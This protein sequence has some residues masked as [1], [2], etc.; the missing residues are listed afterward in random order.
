MRNKCKF[1]ICLLLA[2]TTVSVAYS[3]HVR[4]N[5]K[6]DIECLSSEL[7]GS[8]T[9]QVTGAGKNKSDAQ[10]QAKKNA[11]FEIIF[12]GI[13][14]GALDSN[15]KPLIT[16]VNAR[17]KHE[18]YFNKFFKDNGDYLKYVS[19]AD[20][21]RFSKE[22]KKNKYENSYRLTIRVLRSELKARLKKDGILK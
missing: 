4:T 5:N 17:E 6:S 14:N 12:N 10:E 11:V 18:D 7:D 22:I 2:I 19:K 21:K 8:V 20:A 16:E 15:C 9:V 13:H 3:Q 1:L